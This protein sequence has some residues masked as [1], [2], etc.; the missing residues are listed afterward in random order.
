MHNSFSLS[1]LWLLIKKQW[2]D[3]AKLYSLSVLALLG[4]L[5]I[6]FIF[7]SLVDSNNHYYREEST[8]AI[9]FIMLFAAG[10]IFASTTFATLGDKAKGIYWLGVPATALEKLAC[11]VFYSMFIFLLVYI[12]GFWVVKHITFFII[13][14]NPKNV[15]T[16]AAAGDIFEKEVAP[17]IFYTFIALQSLFILGSVYFERFA[18]IK[19][20]LVIL[21]IAFLFTLFVQLLA[22][23]L[24]PDSFGMEN[25]TTIKIYENN[26]PAKIYKLSHWFEDI[27]TPLVKF[28]WAPVF[29]TATYFRLKE[30]EI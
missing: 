14:L 24:L 19:T 9:F 6:I 8:N 22:H 7:W 17:V 12:A 15:I 20:V 11:G 16:R 4:L 25:F 2:F 27:L 28:I 23:K 5:I 30:K 29:I 10:L 13:E 1:R 3:N 26:E 18:F 21:F